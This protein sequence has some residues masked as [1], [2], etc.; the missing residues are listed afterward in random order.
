MFYVTLKMIYFKLHM[1]REG[2]IIF[3]ILMV[4]EVFSSV[5]F[6]CSVVYDFYDPMDCSTQIV[7]H[8]LPE[9][10]QTHVH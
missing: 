5:Q 2:T 10:T 3:S 9:P 8:Q 6:S 4:F 7:H 1:A